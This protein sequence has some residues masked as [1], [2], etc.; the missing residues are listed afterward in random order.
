M[1]AKK[2]KTRRDHD[3][4]MHSAYSRVAAKAVRAGNYKA[5]DSYAATAARYLAKYHARKAAQKLRKEK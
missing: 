5:A 4:A 1:Y 3:L 2:P